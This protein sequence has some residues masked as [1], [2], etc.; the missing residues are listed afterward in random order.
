M[1][2]T[3]PESYIADK[4]LAHTMACA[5]FE[6]FR[7]GEEA[8]NDGNKDLAS[9]YFTSVNELGIFAANRYIDK[10]YRIQIEEYGLERQHTTDLQSAV[11]LGYNVISSQV[12]RA[13]FDLHY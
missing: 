4:D 8:K 11:N 6:A 9:Q 3:I 1:V 12:I 13:L 10:L 2:D 5:E 7:K